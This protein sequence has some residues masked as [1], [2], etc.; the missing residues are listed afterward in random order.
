MC[1]GAAAAGCEDGATAG[2]VPTAG[3]VMDHGVTGNKKGVIMRE[4]SSSWK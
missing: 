4:A 2:T 3:V 1:V